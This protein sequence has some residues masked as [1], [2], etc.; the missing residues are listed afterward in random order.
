MIDL[1]CGDCLKILPT[2]AAGSVDAVVT[3]PPYPEI[4]REYGRMTE[5]SWHELMRGVVKETRRVL[6]PTGSAVFILQANSER[7]GR[8]RPWLWEFMAW[9]A[10]EWNMV[11]DAYWWNF[12]APPTV[13]AHEKRGLMKP[14]LKAC[15]WLGDP[16]CFRAQNEVLWTPSDSM[17]A[18]SKS[19]RAL[20]YHPSGL[21][22]RAGRIA[23]KV[24]R[25]GGCSPFNV[26]PVANANSTDSAGSEGHGAGTPQPLCDWWTRYL[27]PSGGT[28]LDPFMGSGTTGRVA[29][30][31]GL[32]YIGI[33]RHR[34]YYAIA[35]RRINAALKEV[36]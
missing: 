14:S 21:T 25:R 32:S 9:T 13:H 11:Q 33:E 4:D 8:M 17:L 12:T 6:K 7:V 2:L 15:V 30:S 18:Q 29:V 20:R 19:D 1:R 5:A 31:R 23:E 22:V 3:D 28:V 36:A 10:R 35:R 16:K 34:P 24:E 27:V 26:I